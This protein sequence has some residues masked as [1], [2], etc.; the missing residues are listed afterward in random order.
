MIWYFKWVSK[1]FIKIKVTRIGSL[2]QKYYFW[3]TTS[4]LLTY[5]FTVV[6]EG[7]KGWVAQKSTAIETVPILHAQGKKLKDSSIYRSHL[8]LAFYNIWNILMCNLGGLKWWLLC[9]QQKRGVAYGIWFRYPHTHAHNYFC[10][11]FL[12]TK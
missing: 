7:L 2:V 3:H 1:W 5:V 8:K 9:S 6:T 12:V 4:N 10:V 11:N